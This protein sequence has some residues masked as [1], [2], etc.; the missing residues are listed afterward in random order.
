MRVRTADV[1]ADPY[2]TRMPGLNSESPKPS[3]TLNPSCAPSSPAGP[4]RAPNLAETLAQHHDVVII[5]NL[6]TGRRENIEHL[7]AG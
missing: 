5:D 1:L 4:A 2:Q 7:L 6:A 3:P